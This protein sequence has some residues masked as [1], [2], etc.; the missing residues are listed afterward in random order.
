MRKSMKTM[1]VLS[2]AMLIC[3][4]TNAFAATAEKTSPAQE[5]VLYQV[6]E[7]TDVKILE[8]RADAGISE[9]PAKLCPSFEPNLQLKGHVKHKMTTQKLQSKRLETGELV[10]KYSTNVFVDVD[11][12]V[13][14]AA[15]NGELFIPINDVSVIGGSATFNI[16]VTYELKTFASQ[17]YRSVENVTIK[18]VSKREDVYGNIPNITYMYATAK[19]SSGVVNSNGVAS[20]KQLNVKADKSNP[21]PGNTAT[22]KNPDFGSYYVLN[23]KIAVTGACYSKDI[24]LHPDWEVLFGTTWL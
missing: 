3:L 15:A 1:L 21:F 20:V 12:A 5:T 16:Q 14:M 17:Y 22:A 4:S 11:Q 24:G 19:A 6:Q 23:G 18:Y 7:I 2:L 13:L 8:A 9:I 10:D